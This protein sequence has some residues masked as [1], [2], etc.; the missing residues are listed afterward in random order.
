VLSALAKTGLF[1]LAE[2]LERHT[3]Y[4]VTSISCFVAALLMPYCISN[5]L[6]PAAT[7]ALLT[8]AALTVTYML[9]GGQL[10]PLPASMPSVISDYTVV[11]V[12]H[13][14]EE[15]QLPCRGSYYVVFNCQ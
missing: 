5:A 8:K 3:A 2:H 13:L 12:V 10:P 11:V 15:I 1:N 9:S 14:C 7:A 4:T 6:L